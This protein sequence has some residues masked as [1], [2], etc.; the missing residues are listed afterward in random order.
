MTRPLKMTRAEATEWRGRLAEQKRAA[1]AS[2]A[3]EGWC[4]RCLAR[5]PRKG[6]TICRV[7]NQA[8]LDYYYEHRTAKKPR[9]FPAGTK[10]PKR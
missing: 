8:A 2:A 6:F 7:C 3:A 5:R 1:R 10:P 9:K 4:L